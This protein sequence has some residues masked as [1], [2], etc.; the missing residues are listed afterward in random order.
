MQSHSTNIPAIS[1]ISAVAVSVKPKSFL[2]AR[3]ANLPI[4][5]EWSEGE[6]KS[7]NWRDIPGRYA[8]D[9]Q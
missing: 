4:D 8:A 6:C 5:S 3:L 1:S 2:N 9:G 7:G